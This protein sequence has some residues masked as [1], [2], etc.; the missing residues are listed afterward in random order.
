MAKT[1]RPSRKSPAKKSPAKKS[2]A[3]KSPV[4]KS[5]PLAV[6]RSD[7]VKEKPTLAE[8]AARSVEREPRAFIEG[9]ITTDALAEEL[10]E[11]AVRAMTSGEDEPGEPDGPGVAEAGGPYVVS[12]IVD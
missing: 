8:R 1:K 2:P 6:E 5:P 3:K 4:R 9:K 10:G 11:D 12:S 7:A